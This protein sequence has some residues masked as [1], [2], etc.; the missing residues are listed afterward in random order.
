M[1]PPAVYLQTVPEPE[2][3]GGTNADLLDWAINLRKAVRQ[4]N[5]DKRGLQKWLQG[6]ALAVL[7]F[8]SPRDLIQT[9]TCNTY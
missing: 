1:A 2:L 7:T 8:S 9:G 5:S 3:K 6:S 4:S